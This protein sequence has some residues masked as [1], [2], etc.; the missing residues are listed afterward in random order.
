TRLTT[1]AQL[2]TT[3]NTTWDHI[4]HTLATPQPT[5]TYSL[6]QPAPE[7][8]ST[9]KR[10]RTRT[11]SS[12]EVL[13]ADRKA[14]INSFHKAL[15]E[16][17]PMAFSYDSIANSINLSATALRR[18]MEGKG[19]LLSFTYA[20]K[21]ITRYGGE[22]IE[23]LRRLYEAACNPQE[24]NVFHWGENT[25]HPTQ[26][27]ISDVNKS[28]ELNKRNLERAEIEKDQTLFREEMRKYHTKGSGKPYS[29]AYAASKAV[30]HNEWTI[31]KSLKH[32]WP[33]PSEG[34]AWIDHVEK[35]AAESARLL[36][37]YN[38]ASRRVT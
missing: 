5:T 16:A 2:T 25:A 13:I 28:G 21:I 35:D 18:C 33:S 17:I 10:K 1:R 37:I 31:P 6:T 32:A 36:E 26:E 14:A 30:F 19:G 34:K 24:G 38:R 27:S 11:V 20:N 15:G 3:P 29:P 4:W 12:M 9:G 22:Q 7:R 23:T 8:K